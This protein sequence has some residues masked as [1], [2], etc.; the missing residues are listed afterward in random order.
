MMSILRS[1]RLPEQKLGLLREIAERNHGG[2]QTQ[3]L[4]EAINRYHRELEPASVQGYIRIDRVKDLDREAGCPGCG[5]SRRPGR[6]VAI[7]SD[8]TVKGVFC[9]D[10]VNAGQA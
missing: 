5:Q 2:N 10:C 1:F 7:R 4:I 6:W 9:D 8:G 3:A